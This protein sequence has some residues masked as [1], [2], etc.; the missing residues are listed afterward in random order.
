[1]AELLMLIL[2]AMSLMGAL[3][4]FTSNRHWTTLRTHVYRR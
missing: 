3:S 2:M 4:L 1:M